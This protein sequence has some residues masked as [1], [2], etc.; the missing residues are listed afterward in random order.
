MKK[1]TKYKN[2]T[3]FLVVVK[4]SNGSTYELNYR[5]E[6]KADIDTHFTAIKYPEISKQ[7]Y[8]L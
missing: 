8:K 2:L 7:W 1:V 4:Q 6:V 3:A 5:M